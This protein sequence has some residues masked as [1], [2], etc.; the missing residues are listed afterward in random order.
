MKTIRMEE[1]TWPEIRDAI[2][3]GFTTVVMAVGSTEQHGPHL[4][5]MTDTRIGDALAQ[6]VAVKLGK[7]LQARTVPFGCSE[8]HL[9]FGGTISLKPDTLRLVLLD[10]VDSLI[11]DGFKRVIFLPSHGGNF[12]T[13]RQAVEE[14]RSSHSGVDITGYTD[15]QGFVGVL[16]AAS[17]EFG[18]GEE[19]SGAH[20][21]ES[22]TSIMM[23]LE[24]SLV[25]A[26]RLAPGYLGPTGEKELALILEKGMPALTSNGVLGDPRRA[27]AEKG[28]RYLDKL[29]GFLADYF[30]RTE[31]GG[32]G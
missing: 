31:A 27:S 9:A 12:G 13:V 6:V 18:I 28:R 23:D 26:D 17:A 21:G 29:A 5:T 3:R 7:A 20:A 32:T 22:E 10:A 24:G 11:R 14:A 19:E 30:S 25:E 15:L 16:F 8:H 1:M 4:P 2:D